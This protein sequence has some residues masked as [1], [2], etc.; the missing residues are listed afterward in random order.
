V[1]FCNNGVSK[2]DIRRAELVIGIYHRIDDLIWMVQHREG[3]K[4]KALYGV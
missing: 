3:K 2:K 4:E 1:L